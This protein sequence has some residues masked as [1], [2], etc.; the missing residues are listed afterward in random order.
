[1]VRYPSHFALNDLIIFCHSEVS[2]DDDA[3]FYAD[4]VKFDTV[5]DGG[6]EDCDIALIGGE[7]DEVD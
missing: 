2:V 7:Y 4:I 6:E 1:M 3:D 5:E